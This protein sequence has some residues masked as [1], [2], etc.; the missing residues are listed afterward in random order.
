MYLYIYSDSTT[1]VPLA[2]QFK[3]TIQLSRR[4]SISTYD[5]GVAQCAN[6]KALAPIGGRRALL[7]SIGVWI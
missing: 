5:R 2:T 4:V 1:Q 6:V 3:S 7:D